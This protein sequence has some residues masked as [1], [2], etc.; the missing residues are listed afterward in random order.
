MHVSLKVREIPEPK[1]IKTWFWHKFALWY[2]RL[3]H[4]YGHT[5]GPFIGILLG[6]EYCLKVLDPATVI[7]K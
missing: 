1:L 3:R 4:K 6:H 7:L 2:M 5:G